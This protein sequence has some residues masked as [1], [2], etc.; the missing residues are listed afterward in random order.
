MIKKLFFLIFIVPVIFTSCNRNRQKNEARD[1]QLTEIQKK[2]KIFNEGLKNDTVLYAA[3]RELADAYTLFINSHPTDTMTPKFIYTLGV[4]NVKYLADYQLAIQ[5]FT[6]LYEK[7][8]KYDRTPEGLFVSANLY[9]DFLKKTDKAR[10]YFD[11]I[12]KEYPG[13][14]LAEDSRI[15]L[16]NLGKT[17]EDLWNDIQKQKAEKEKKE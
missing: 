10:E 1:N 8:P 3:G 12:I 11:V 4:M 5:Y 14:K 13:N 16:R 15:L 9:N 17:N 7:F 6:M 2:E